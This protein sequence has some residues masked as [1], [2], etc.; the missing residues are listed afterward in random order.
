MNDNALGALSPSEKFWRDRYNWL[1]QEGYILRPRYKP[2]WVPSWKDSG[3][4]HWSFEDGQRLI[5]GLLH[6]QWV[7][8][9]TGPLPTEWSGHRR[10][11]QIRRRSGSLKESL[12]VGPP[13]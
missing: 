5:V 6:L 1:E 10:R 13:I 9:L 7:C 11:S 4:G 2:D 8:P 12:E 3:R